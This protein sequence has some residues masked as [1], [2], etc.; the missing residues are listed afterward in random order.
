MS[1]FSWKRDS[2]NVMWLDTGILILAR[3]ICAGLVWTVIIAF[4]AKPSIVELP[5]FFLTYAV[6]FSLLPLVAIVISM[7]SEV[8]PFIGLM[9]LLIMLILL[10]GDPI[11]FIVH[12]F[13]PQFVPVESYPIISF[14][15]LT[16]VLRE[17]S[18]EPYD[19]EPERKE[20]KVEEMKKEQ[21]GPKPCPDCDGPVLFGSENNG[22]CGVCHGTGDSNIPEFI[23]G[24]NEG[25]CYNCKGTGIC[26]TCNGKGMID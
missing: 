7:L 21:R 8:I 14:R 19:D 3:G 5:L 16:W 11:L 24:Q 26:P 1:N 17:L 23:P 15:A 9:N 10:P 4:N 6:M 13:L 20:R 18:S 25:N 22:K 12:K 2:K